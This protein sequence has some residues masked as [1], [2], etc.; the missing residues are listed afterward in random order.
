MDLPKKSGREEKFNLEES[1]I[2]RKNVVSSQPSMSE[3]R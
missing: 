1:V 3:K 2:C